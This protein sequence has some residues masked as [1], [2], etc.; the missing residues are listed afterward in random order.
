MVKGLRTFEDSINTVF[1]TAIHEA[2]Q[3]YVEALYTKSS[4]EADKLEL[5]KIF[6]EKL[7]NEL[8]EKKVKYTDDE[9]TEFIFNGE[10]IIQEFTKS[11]NRT[12][13]FPTGKYELV[14][15]EEELKMPIRGGI[16]FSGYID[17][18]LRE[19]SSG[20]IKIYD[21]KTSTQGW[22]EYQ[23][24]DETKT[25]QILLY[26]ALYSKKFNI[27]LNMIDV[28]FFILKRNLLEGVNFPQSRIQ[29]FVPPNNNKAVSRTLNNF[30]EFVNECFDVDGQYNTDLSKYPKIPGKAKKNCKYCP[31]KKINCDTKADILED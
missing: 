31:H 1:G 29:I 19:K 25:S 20:R 22:N 5:F 13:H 26:K 3:S 17:L 21:F 23:R 7:Q 4:V 11:V 18:I 30:A 28:E 10:D 16:V 8:K 15:I 6:K 2:V 9:L 24:E 27:P 12:K 14:G